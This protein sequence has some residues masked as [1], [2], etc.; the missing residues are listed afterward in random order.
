MLAGAAAMLV[1]WFLPFGT[2]EETGSIGG[3]E[4]Q[5]VRD[6]SRTVWFWDLSAG[7]VPVLVAP[8]ILILIAWRGHRSLES[9]GP[10]VLMLLVALSANTYLAA[11]IADRDVRD[12]PTPAAVAQ[13]DPTARCDLVEFP[14]T[15]RS[16]ALGLEEPMS[17]LDEEIVQAGYDEFGLSSFRTGIGSHLFITIS[18]LIS[19]ASAWVLFR[20]RMSRFGASF[21]IAV[22][23]VLIYVVTFFDWVSHLA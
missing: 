7:T 12:I 5:V 2:L 6:F 4:E 14:P 11:S 3:G 20:R 13:P 1:G 23:V 9:S 18:F 21:V 22:G 19:L 10:L 17:K 16:C 15:K 8:L